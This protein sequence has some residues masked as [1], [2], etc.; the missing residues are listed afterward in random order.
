MFSLPEV[1]SRIDF[2]LISNTLIDS[3]VDCEIGAIAFSDHVIAELHVDLDGE[4]VKRGRWRLNTILLQNEKFSNTVSEDLK[5]FFEIHIS[6]TLKISYIWEAS[7][8][9]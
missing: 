1:N 4:V 6:S 9:I 5:F 8:A 7:K 3:V 2:I